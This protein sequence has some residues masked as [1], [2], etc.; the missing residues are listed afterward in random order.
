MNN[1]NQ[2]EVNVKDK[3]SR[4]SRWLLIILKSSKFLKLF[5]ILKLLKFTKPLVTIIS[6]SLSALV[7]SKFLGPWFAI[8][9]VMLLFVHEMGH[10][11]ALKQ[12]GLKTSAPVFIPMLGAVVFAPKFNDPETEAHVGYGGPLFGAIISWLIAAVWW[13]L[14]DR[15]I[16]LLMLAYISAFINIFNL[17]PLRPLDGGRI[18]QAIGRWYKYVGIMMLLLFTLYV[19]EPGYLLIWILILS[20]IKL[21]PK[22]RVSYAGACL[23]SMVTL[24]LLGYSKQPLLVDAIDITFGSMVSISYFFQSLEDE[25]DTVVEEV[26]ELPAK[27]RLKWFIYYNILFVTLLGLMLVL[28]PHLPK[29]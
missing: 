2:G 11:V 6:M 1:P 14:P 8:G 25:E 28:L 22:L 19:R 16:V 24:M 9:L 5:K 26:K 7:Y 3:D 15:P 20:D 23:V 12:K 18:T 17:I 29:K 10:V 27:Q 21:K 13:F 4:L